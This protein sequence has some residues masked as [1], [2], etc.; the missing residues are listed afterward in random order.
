MLLSAG[1]RMSIVTKFCYLDDMVAGDCCGD[2]CAVDARIEGRQAR[3][4]V[5]CAHASSQRLLID[6]RLTC[7]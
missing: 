7:C 2:A 4:L 3:H 6:I 5:C 1:R